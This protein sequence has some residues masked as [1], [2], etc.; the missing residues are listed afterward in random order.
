MDIV[1]WLRNS[2][3]WLNDGECCGQK[4]SAGICAAP[5]CIFG[6]AVKEFHNA[7]DFIE[8]MRES[9]REVLRIAD[10]DTVE[11]N[12]LRAVLGENK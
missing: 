11:F 7:A 1:R 6:E 4:D 2:K 12:R 8:E 5:A 3:H 10:R 9:V